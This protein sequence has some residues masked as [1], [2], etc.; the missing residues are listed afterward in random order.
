MTI[1]LMDEGGFM[2]PNFVQATCKKLSHTSFGLPMSEKNLEEEIKKGSKKL[3]RKKEA[4]IENK[5]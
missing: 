3:S 5:G 2:L 4:S 1:R